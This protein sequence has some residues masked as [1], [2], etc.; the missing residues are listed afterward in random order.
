MFI[1]LP[2]PNLLFSRFPRETAHLAVNVGN[3]AE[4]DSLLSPLIGWQQPDVSSIAKAQNIFDEIVF[5]AMNTLTSLAA[6]GGGGGSGGETPMT[7]DEILT[8]VQIVSVAVDGAAES[9]PPEVV[10]VDFKRGYFVGWSVRRFVHRSVI[11]SV[12]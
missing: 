10:E 11:Q 2:E 5:P 6:N 8:Q 3:V 7:K 4:R 12:R 1:I 9:M